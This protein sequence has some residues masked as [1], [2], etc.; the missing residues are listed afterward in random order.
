MAAPSIVVV[1][2]F[3]SGATFGYPFIIG[4]GILGTNTLADAAADTVDISNQVSKITINRG[5]N[6]L[7]EEFQAGVASIRI[8]DLNGDWNPTSTTSPSLRLLVTWRNLR[9]FV[10]RTWHGR[11]WGQL[12]MM[13]PSF[14]LV[15]ILVRLECF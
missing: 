8:I 2:D 6:L 11:R 5:Y 13:M 12:R 7:Q 14:G 3:S 15:V 1:F 9:L 4:Q 10:R